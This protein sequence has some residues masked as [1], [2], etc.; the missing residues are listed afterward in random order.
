MK[1]ILLSILILCSAVCMAHQSSMHPDA[2]IRYVKSQIKQKAGPCFDTYLQLIHTVDSLLG[3]SHRAVEDFSVPG[4]YFNAQGHRA[5]SMALSGDAFAAY[6]C[7]LS[8]RL[9]GNRKYGEKA[10]YFLN[11]WASVNK[12]YSEYDGELV[13]A[14][15]GSALLI[16][17]ELMHDSG[18]WKK[19]EKEQFENWV[20]N[21]YRKATDAIRTKPNNWADWGRFGSLLSAS[22]LR[23]KN[24]VQT[25]IQLIR[26][27]I[28]HKIATDGSMTEEVKREK[29]GIWYTYFSL[30]PI[31]AS[32]WVVYNLTGDNLFVDKE[33]RL[34]KKAL[35][36][37]LYY[38][39]QP[40]EWPWFS[41]PRNGEGEH[42][43]EN[44]MQAMSGIYNDKNYLEFALSRRPTIHAYHHHAWTFTGLMPLRPEFVSPKPIF[45]HK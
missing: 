40:D 24:E 27:D 26:S 16:A 14:Y 30:A 22:F 34:I 37:L 15:N 2:Q 10:C 7:A 32:C 19:K 17:A 43:P 29:N 13:M 23:D 9:S 36:Y 39:E 28:D 20:V 5:S 44:L 18:I 42:W 33:G 8:Y 12:K 45:K 11:A 1:K 4:F 41:N 38:T 35:D 21:V 3:V 25:N 6:A 31:T